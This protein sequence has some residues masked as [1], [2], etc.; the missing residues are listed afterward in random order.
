[1]FEKIQSHLRRKGK[2]NKESTTAGVVSSEAQVIG[3]FDEDEWIYER[4]QSD[5]ENYLGEI[6]STEFIEMIERREKNCENFKTESEKSATCNQEKMCENFEGTVPCPQQLDERDLATSIY[7]QMTRFNV[8][9]EDDDYDECNEYVVMVSEESFAPDNEPM[10]NIAKSGTNYA[11]AGEKL[12]ETAVEMKCGEE[13]IEEDEEMFSDEDDNDNDSVM[14]A[15]HEA[16]NRDPIEVRDNSS[17]HADDLESNFVD[18]EGDTERDD[19][20][21]NDDDHQEKTLDCNHD[22]PEPSDTKTLET[23]ESTTCDDQEQS[24]ASYKTDN[25]IPFKVAEN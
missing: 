13:N 12:Q 22:K 18:D 9:D 7:S 24:P 4:S 14:T 19:V 1:M 23:N 25:L 8:E 3:A 16:V 2:E 20:T 21:R 15:K 6:L 11:R 10:D 5:S 17:S